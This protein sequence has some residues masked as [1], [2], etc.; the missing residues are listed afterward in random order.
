[1]D[2]SKKKAL[3]ARTFGVG[4]ARI[5]FNKE[6]LNDIKEAITKQDMRDLLEQKTVLIKEITGIKTN[7]VST[8]RRAGSIKM[9]PNRRRQEYMMM[10][11]KLREYVSQMRNQEKINQKE[12]LILRKEVRARQFKNK[13]GLKERITHLVKE[14][15]VNA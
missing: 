10:V 2:L 14:R 4:E 15:T 9:R 13:N 11:R 3:A 12:F 7:T 1:M 6:R 5:M 8:R